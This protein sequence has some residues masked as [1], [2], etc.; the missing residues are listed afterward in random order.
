[1]C[2]TDSLTPTPTQHYPSQTYAE[3]TLLQNYNYT[4]VQLTCKGPD[5][6]SL[7]QP[8]AGVAPVVLE[9]EV[10]DLAVAGAV[11][12][13]AAVEGV[14]A[15]PDTD[16]RGHDVAGGHVLSLSP[17]HWPVLQALCKCQ[18]SFSFGKRNV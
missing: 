2:N 4:V 12:L 7:K 3:S 5:S 18:C 10:L 16:V 1:M 11:R 14:P 13:A 6:A 17:Q 8:R 9:V 15:D